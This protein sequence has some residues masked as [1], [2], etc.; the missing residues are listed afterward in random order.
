MKRNYTFFIVVCLLYSMLSVIDIIY[1]IDKL[2]LSIGNTLLWAAV[3]LV[4]IEQMSK[5]KVDRKAKHYVGVI[6]A[7]FLLLLAIFRMITR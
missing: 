6:L 7:F 5:V 4:A 1:R 3:F 2:Y